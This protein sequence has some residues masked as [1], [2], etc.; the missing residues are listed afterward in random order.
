MYD[1]RTLPQAAARWPQAACGRIHTSTQHASEIAG[2]SMKLL[3]IPLH[4]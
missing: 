1:P 4:H 2:N 3:G